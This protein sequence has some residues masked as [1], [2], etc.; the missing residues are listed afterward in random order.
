MDSRRLVYLSGGKLHVRTGSGTERVMESAFGRSLRDRA[1]Q[2]RE[3]HAWKTEGRGA[4]FLRG[5][6]W[7]EPKGDPS[8]FRIAITSACR[9]RND[10]EIL[11]TLE[12]DEVSGMFAVDAD[13]AETR[14]FHTADFRLRDICLSPDGTTI[15]AATA[16]GPAQSN[17]ATM[18]LDANHFTEVT[19]GDSIDA[20]PCW[21]PGSGRKLVFQSAG[22]GRNRAGHLTGISPF[23]IQQLDLHSGELTTLAEEGEHDLIA[24]RV[25][26]DGALY[27]IRR[28]KPN[29]ERGPG[30]LQIAKGIVLLPFRL[31]HAVFQYF[32]L[33]SMMYTGKPLVDQ[34]GAVARPMDPRQMIVNGNLAMALQGVQMGSAGEPQ[35]NVPT[36]WQLLRRSPDGRR[37]VLAKSVVTYDL[38]PRRSVLYSTGEAAH[39]LPAGGRP[40]QVCS[41]GLIE[42]VAMM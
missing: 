32:N 25:D 2:I 8:E 6:M 40:E 16:G 26:E 18:D 21:V 15:A 4:Q 7:G 34:K 27:Y 19:E 33:F 14:L 35:W 12:T 3:R 42:Y 38:G 20:A 11:Y 29:A 37:E 31:A 9:G 39:L 5:S 1:L 24:P 28:P 17:I 30:P 41:G 36:S 23:T 22:L 13:G 10:G